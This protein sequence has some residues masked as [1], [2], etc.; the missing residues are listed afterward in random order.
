MKKLLYIMMTHITCSF[1][2]HQMKTV[3][4]YNGSTNYKCANCNEHQ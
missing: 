2:G 4:T 3:Y 1:T